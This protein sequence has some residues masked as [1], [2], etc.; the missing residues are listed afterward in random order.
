MPRCLATVAGLLLLAGSFAEAAEAAFRLI[1]H[2]ANPVT[3]LSRDQ[4]SRLFLKKSTEWDRGQRVAAVD[5]AE[6][7]Q[8]RATFSQAVHGRSMAQ[9][10]SYWQQQI[11]SGKDV[12]LPEKAS[13]GEVLAFVQANPNA[14]GY[15]SADTTPARVKVVTVTE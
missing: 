10:R 9:I 14:I 1:V 2:P 11:F 8:V 12:P 7:R 13:D 6:Q 3:T 15:I 5:Q 4:V